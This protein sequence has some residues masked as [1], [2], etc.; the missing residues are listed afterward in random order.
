[1]ALLTSKKTSSDNEMA[2]DFYFPTSKKAL[3]IFTRNPELGKVKTRLAKSVGDESALEIYKFLLKHTVEITKNLN[4]DKYV[5]YSE[6][7]HRDDIWNPDIFRK[8]LQSGENLGEKMNNAFSELFDM[9]YESVLIVGSDIFEINQKDIENAFDALQSNQLVIG[10]AKDGGYYLLGMKELDSKIFKNKNW[11][12][13]TVLD[14]TLNDLRTKKY[15]LLEER[16][17]IDYY[18]DIKEVDAFQQFLPPY[19]D[20]N[21]L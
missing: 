14:D 1:M 13:N 9:G 4:V 20:K 12:T 19:L 17:D 11:G 6:N 8:K 2:R 16:N 18:Q 3:I 21:F 15:V 10:P 5:F 7:I